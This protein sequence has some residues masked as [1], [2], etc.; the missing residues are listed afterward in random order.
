MSKEAEEFLQKIIDEEL[1]MCFRDCSQDNIN[2]FAEIL[3]RYHQSRVN[4]I[5]D[6]VLKEL[7]EDIKGMHPEYIVEHIEEQL[8]KQ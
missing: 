2:K 4:A 6:E 3:D 1:T 7:L 8:L 5:S